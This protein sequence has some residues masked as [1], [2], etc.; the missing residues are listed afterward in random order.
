MDPAVAAAVSLERARWSESSATVHAALADASARIA[1]L[2]AENRSISDSAAVTSQLAVETTAL[3]LSSETSARAAQYAAEARA[4][5]AERA[6]ADEQAAR[7]FAVHLALTS[8]AP[9]LA[10]LQAALR[11]KT[12]ECE[13]MSDWATDRD[14]AAARETGLRAEL[15]AMAAGR[16]DDISALERRNAAD[17]EGIRKLMMRHLLD[18][19]KELLTHSADS[20]DDTTKRVITQHEQLLDELNYT[21]THAQKLLLEADEANR[22]RLRALGGA[23]A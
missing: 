6:L 4:A 10:R 18:F 9:E 15:A 5:A 23:A 22:V 11:D 8:S 1:S 17:R 21:S 14:E 7:D 13:R 2:A 3:A 12:N 16:A 19:K 20:L